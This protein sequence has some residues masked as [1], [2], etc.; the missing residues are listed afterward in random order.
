MIYELAYAEFVFEPTYWPS[1]T[2]KILEKN[3]E[4]FLKRNRRYGGI[5]K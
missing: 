2:P 1:Y 4:E 3:L 5:K